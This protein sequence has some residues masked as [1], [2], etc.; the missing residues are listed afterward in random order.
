MASQKQCCVRL[1]H[2]LRDHAEHG[3]AQ[4]LVPCYTEALDIVADSVWAAH[5]AQVLHL[6]SAV[7]LFL[8]FSC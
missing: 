7:R 5:I 2:V 8:S 1:G 6:L 4:V 3:G